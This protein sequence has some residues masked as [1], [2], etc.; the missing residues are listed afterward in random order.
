MVDF[1]AL[2]S[3]WKN[4]KNLEPGDDDYELVT[5]R[6]KQL[7]Q[8]QWITKLVLFG[9]LVVLAFFFIYVSAFKNSTMTIGLS[10]MMGS[11]ALRILIEFYSTKKLK[12]IGTFVSVHVFKAKLVNYYKARTKTHYVVSPLIVMAYIAGFM[13]M[14]PLFKMNLSPGFYLYIVISAIVVL[15]VLGAF[16]LKKV[17]QE[18]RDLKTLQQL[19]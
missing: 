8:D 3:Q 18:L 5:K 7:R 16:I 6:L 11:L 14:L 13:M 10:L 17:R 19:E 12:S 2:Q 1:N 9:T 4:Q 15:L